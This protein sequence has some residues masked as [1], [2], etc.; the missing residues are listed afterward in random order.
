VHY[1]PKDIIKRSIYR[2]EETKK[3]KHEIQTENRSGHVIS[4]K[5]NNK[6]SQKDI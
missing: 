5:K 6:T 4:I 3:E 2:K 1:N